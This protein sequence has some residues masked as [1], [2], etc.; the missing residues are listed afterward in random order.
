MEP[1]DRSD[2]EWPDASDDW[3]GRHWIIDDSFL[4]LVNAAHKGVEFTLPVSPSGNAWSQIIDTE[5]IGDPFA[6]TA[7]RDKIILGGRSLK[8]LGDGA[9]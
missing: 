4:I 6:K 8:L 7:V 5:N 9:Y 2:A 3:G 1:C